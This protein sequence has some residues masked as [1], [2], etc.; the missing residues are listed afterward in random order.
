MTHSFFCANV[1]GDRARW[2]RQRRFTVLQA[3]FDAGRLFIDTWAAWR[4]DPQR[5][6]RLHFVA[7]GPLTSMVHPHVSTE[8]PTLSQMLIDA[9]PI[10]VTGLHRLEFENGRVVLTLAIGELES[11]LPKIWLRRC[12]LSAA[13]AGRCEAGLCRQSAGSR[14]R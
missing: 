1:L 11:M 13:I 8:Q 6:E 2:A 3:E 10:Q 5:C 4:A 7:V 14:R 9:W 12:L